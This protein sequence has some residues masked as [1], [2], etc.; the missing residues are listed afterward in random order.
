MEPSDSHYLDPQGNVVRKWSVWTWTD[1][2]GQWDEEIRHL[3]RMQE[4]LGPLEDDTR[5]IRA[6]IGSLVTCDS[7]IP[8][9]IDEILCA[10]GKGRLDE[11]TFHNGCWCG[12]MWWEAR[13]T[14]PHQPAA[15]QVV[16]EVLRGYLHGQASKE[17]IAKH[18][19]VEG[20]IRRTYEHLGPRDKLTELQRRAADSVDP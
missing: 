5:Q 2:P 17:L 18:P 9:T 14:Q 19:H 10:I 15:M 12:S 16:E 13:T 20:F 4:Q 7:G 6:H 8:V 3:N 1:E 11:P